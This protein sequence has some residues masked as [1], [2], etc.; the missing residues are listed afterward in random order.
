[1]SP[2]RVLDKSDRYCLIK[3]VLWVK[4]TYVSQHRNL[5]EHIDTAKLRSL[6]QWQFVNDFA[7]ADTMLVLSTCGCFAHH[8]CMH[9][10]VLKLHRKQCTYIDGLKS[11]HAL[12][13]S[14]CCTPIEQAILLVAF[15]SFGGL[16]RMSVSK[17]CYLAMQRLW[18]RSNLF[19]PLTTLSPWECVCVCVCVCV[20]AGVHSHSTLSYYVTFAQVFFQVVRTQIKQQRINCIIDT[21]LPRYERFWGDAWHWTCSNLCW[22][23]STEATQARRISSTLLLSVKVCVGV[24]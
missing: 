11:G 24:R 4:P 10:C 7:P 20:C 14:H 22:K 12:L 13:R 6:N 19:Y 2:V 23:E 16:Q 5:Q 21:H 15:T 17:I 18:G 9:R 3:C 8:T 1:M